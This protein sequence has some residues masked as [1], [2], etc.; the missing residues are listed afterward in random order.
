MKRG[1]CDINIENN[2]CGSKMRLEREDYLVC[3]NCSQVHDDYQ[4]ES[5]YVDF[6]D[7]IRKKS[8]YHRKYHIWN[9]IN[10]IAQKNRIQVDYYNRKKILRIFELIAKVAP[11]VDWLVLNSFESSYLSF[12]GK[13]QVYPSYKV[14]EDTKLLQFLVE[15]SLRVN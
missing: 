3:I 8:I 9:L 15:T 1:L 10:D 14:K 2:T 5:E 12:L 4:P 6:Y 7:K 11:Q 13:I